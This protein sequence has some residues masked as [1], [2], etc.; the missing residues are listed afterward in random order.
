MA[1]SVR[2]EVVRLERVT[3]VPSLLSENFSFLRMI[4]SPEGSIEI[5]V[6]LPQASI[7]RALALLSRL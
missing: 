7:F 3:R 4:S 2:L 6:L 5:N 1:A